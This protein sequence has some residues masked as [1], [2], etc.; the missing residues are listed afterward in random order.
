MAAITSTLNGTDMP[1]IEQDFINT[2]LDKVVDV[3]TL[4]NS[5]YTDFTGSRHQSWTYNYDSLTQD[6]YDA[7]KDAYDG[8]F[9]SYEYPTLS[10]P[11]Y[12]VADQPVR[13]YINEKNIWD[14]CGS[15]QN[16]QIT[17]RETLAIDYVE[18]NYLLID[19]GERLIIDGNTYLIL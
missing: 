7:L 14:N 10:I 6:Q 15:V 11:Y 12:S 3:E 1:P 18:P 2:P 4:D 8:Q 5:I 9:T 16:V 13:M 19:D 17:F